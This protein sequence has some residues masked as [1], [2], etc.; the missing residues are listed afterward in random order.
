MGVSPAD[1]RS[2]MGVGS[3]PGGFAAAYEDGEFHV[4]TLAAL[5]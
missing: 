3:L 4:E 1:S 5:I 2:D